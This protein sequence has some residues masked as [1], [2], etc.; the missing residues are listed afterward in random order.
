MLDERLSLYEDEEERG[1]YDDEIEIMEIN[2]SGETN[3][4]T[5]L[6]R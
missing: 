5:P 1:W 3:E 2:P 4:E 6:G